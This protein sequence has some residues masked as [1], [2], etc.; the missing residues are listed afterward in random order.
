MS[1][2]DINIEVLKEF[3]KKKAKKISRSKNVVNIHV[4]NTGPPDISNRNA[5]LKVFKTTEAYE[6]FRS[7]YLY[8]DFSYTMEQEDRSI[9]IMRNRCKSKKRRQENMY[10]QAIKNKNAL[11]QNE[12][13][14]KTIFSERNYYNNYSREKLDYEAAEKLLRQSS[15]SFSNQDDF[16]YVNDS[17]VNNMNQIN[18]INEFNEKFKEDIK[19]EVI[20]EKSDDDNKENMEIDENDI[21]ENEEENEEEEEVREKIE[22][23]EDINRDMVEKNSS[24][25]SFSFNDSVKTTE[26]KRNSNESGSSRFPPYDTNSTIT[27]SSARIPLS[28]DDLIKSSPVK[29]PVIQPRHRKDWQALSLSE[30]S[31]KRPVWNPFSSEPKKKFIIPGIDKQYQQYMPSRKGNIFWKVCDGNIYDNIF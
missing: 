6:A 26:S 19:E 1:T 29:L 9:E 27:K 31:E 5:I 10:R 28:M 12:K 25:K 2:K 7:K 15:D 22:I 23:A 13:L 30:V 11:S 8:N 21:K 3:R 17:G 18:T 20:E 4:K 24:Y 16:E 14:H